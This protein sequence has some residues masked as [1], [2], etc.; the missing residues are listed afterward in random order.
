MK[1]TKSLIKELILEEMNALKYAEDK[2]KGQT[3]KFGGTPY[4][5]HPKNVARLAKKNGF[6]VHIV[7]AAYLH[8]TLE[9]T[10]ATY[11]DIHELFG[12]VVANLVLELTNNEDDI[13][14]MGKTLYMINKLSK[15]S[16]DALSIKLL[17]R[18]DNVS[19]FETAG[20]KFVIKYSKATIDII[21]GIREKNIKLTNKQEDI[22]EQIL[23]IAQPFYNKYY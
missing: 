3:R 1:I 9:D 15:L 4:V 14:T 20:E 6:P 23:E 5:E 11:E 16:T 8:D 18:L 10:D 21:A 7:K 17:D 2:H 12:E 22:I 19:D 13:K